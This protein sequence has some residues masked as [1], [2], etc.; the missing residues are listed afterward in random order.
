MKAALVLA[1][2]LAGFDAGAASAAEDAFLSRL[3][4]EWIGR[5]T[6]RTS[7]QAEPERV[8]CRIANTLSSDGRTLQQKGRCSLASNS[9]PID[10][11]IAALG[12]NLYGGSLNSLASRGPTTIAGSANGSRLE[13]SADFVDSFD[14]KPA[15]ATIVIH[16]VSGGGYRL[17]STRVHPETGEPYTASEIVFA[18]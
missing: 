2:F 11:T 5:G 15:R 6:M 8:Y 1:A 13:L 17:T 16:L 18:E 9:G 3:V 10:G 14:G 4:G 7:P 12:S